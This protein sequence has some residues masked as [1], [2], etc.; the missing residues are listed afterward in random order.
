MLTLPS[1]EARRAPVLCGLTAAVLLALASPASAREVSLW[2]RIKADPRMAHPDAMTLSEKRALALAYGFENLLP[3]RIGSTVLVSNCNDAGPGSLLDAVTS[4]SSGDTV[5]AS[6]LTC[7]MITL[8]TGA[9]S[10][11][12]D[13]LTIARKI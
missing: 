6:A 13:G 10:T 12:A 11:I 1:S 2:E 8:T 3:T 4:A 5:D 9:L 7:S